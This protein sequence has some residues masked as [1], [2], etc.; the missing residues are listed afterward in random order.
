MIYSIIFDWKRTLYDPESKAL[1]PGASQII[2]ACFDLKIPLYLI[3]KGQEEMYSEVKRLGVENYFEKILFVEGSKNPKDF[4]S[5]IDK[6][7]PKNT[8][9]IGDR[10]RSELQV[11]KSLGCTTVWIKQGKFA[12]EEPE[13]PEQNPDYVFENLEQAISLIFVSCQVVGMDS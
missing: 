10:I 8:F 4:E 9:V 11:G 7:I 3:G 6:L 2:K 1:I 12:T 13:S 5:C